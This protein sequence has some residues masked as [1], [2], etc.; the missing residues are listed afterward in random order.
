[1]AR[2]NR[3][4]NFKYEIKRHL[5]V[6]AHGSKSWSKQVNF[7][8]WGDNPTVLDIR[9]WDYYQQK[10]GKGITLTRDEACRLRDVLNALNL[11]EVE[12]LNYPE[13]P[14]EAQARDTGFGF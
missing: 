12:H 9:D 14:E 6:L 1:M 13:Q 8:S 10:S 4:S 7:V 3:D 5:G 11:G 2:Y